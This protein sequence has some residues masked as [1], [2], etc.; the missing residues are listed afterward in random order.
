[1]GWVYLPGGL[2]GRNG[3]FSTGGLA[4]PVTAGQAGRWL[5]DRRAY[6]THKHNPHSA[7][8]EVSGPWEVSLSLAFLL[9]FLG[10]S[11]DNEL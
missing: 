2:W 1:M 6:P 9:H 10:L 8:I 3:S 5:W 7:L 11:G 4:E